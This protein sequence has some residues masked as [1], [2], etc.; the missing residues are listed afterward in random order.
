MHTRAYRRRGRV[1]VLRRRLQAFYDCEE[2]D[3]REIVSAI[4]ANRIIGNMIQH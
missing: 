1:V 2:N 3:L 4:V